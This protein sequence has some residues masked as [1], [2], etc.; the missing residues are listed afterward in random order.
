MGSGLQAP[1]QIEK[2]MVNKMKKKVL[3]TDGLAEEAI[4]K[5]KEHFDV[6]KL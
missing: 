3:I 2:Q 4:K 1:I 5:L 6:V